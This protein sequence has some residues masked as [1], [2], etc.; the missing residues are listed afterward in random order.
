[1]SDTMTAPAPAGTVEITD[2]AVK[3]IAWVLNQDD[4]RGR[5]LRISVSGG[6]CSGFQYGFTFDDATTEADL[7]I[8]RD[9]AK[10]LIDDVSLDMLRGSVIDYVEDMIGASFAIRNPQAKSSC[11]CGNSFST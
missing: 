8:E 6:G 11:G 4:Y 5:M 7:V 2:S 10:V 3:R 9:G 1:M